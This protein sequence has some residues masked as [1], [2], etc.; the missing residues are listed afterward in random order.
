[1]TE[2]ARRRSRR[3]ATYVLDAHALYWYLHDP[4]RLSR[5]AELALDAVAAGVLF[6]T[7][8]SVGGFSFTPLG[9]R[10]LE[11]LDELPQIPEMHDR[12]IAAE[13]RAHDAVVISRDPVFQTSELISTLW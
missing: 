6:G 4:V 8:A 1:M 3:R 7:L 11:L 10:Q 13:A 9:R 5:P 2:R 12:L